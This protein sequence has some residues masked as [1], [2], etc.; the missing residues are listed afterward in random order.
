MARLSPTAE[1]IAVLAMEAELRGRAGSSQP[2]DI[3]R[4]FRSMARAL[5]PDH[6]GGDAEEFARLVEAKDQVLVRM[7]VTTRIA[8]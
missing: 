4:A 7:G 5:H 8:R 3:R 6:V 1:R 2:P